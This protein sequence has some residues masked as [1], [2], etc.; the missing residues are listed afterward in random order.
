V[1]A[2]AGLSLESSAGQVSARLSQSQVVVPQ[3][4]AVDAAAPPIDAQFLEQSYDQVNI[5]AFEGMDEMTPRLT[6]ASTRKG[7]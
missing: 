3:T 7:R 5:K 6:Q 4:Q 1:A 2:A